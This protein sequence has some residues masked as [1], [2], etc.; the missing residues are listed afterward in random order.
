MY[1]FSFNSG[2]LK[3]NRLYHYPYFLKDIIK[4]GDVCIDIGANLGYITVPLSKIV[5]K[6]GKVYSFEP[7]KPILS[8]LRSNTKRCKNVTIYPYA[9]GEE[10]KKITLGNNSL[11]DKGFIA[12]GSHFIKDANENT[13]VEFEAEM[14]VGSEMFADLKQLDFIKCDI[15][16]YEVVVIPELE[17][18][19]TKFKPMV[20]IEARDESRR[21][22]IEF[23]ESRGYKSYILEAN[24]LIKAEVEQFWDIL[25]V[26]PDSNDRIQQFL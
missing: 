25:F 8:V 6:E 16:G 9:L 7:V 5:G 14:K 2:M 1:F 13:D 23:F 3:K 12:S 26:H 19:I 24:K 20:L 21:Q 17:P 22:M 10:N 18:V 4:K 11:K 15:E